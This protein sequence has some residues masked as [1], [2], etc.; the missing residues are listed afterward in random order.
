MKFD[1]NTFLFLLIGLPLAAAFTWFLIIMFKSDTQDFKFDIQMGR[2]I[3]VPRFSK[4][5]TVK[6]VDRGNERYHPIYCLSCFSIN[7]VYFDMDDIYT[8]KIFKDCQECNKTMSVTLT[9]KDKGV[10]K[11]L[12]ERT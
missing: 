9:V 7:A 6:Q 12:I 4:S 11:V 3:A 2:P 10:D 5:A 8:H 1:S